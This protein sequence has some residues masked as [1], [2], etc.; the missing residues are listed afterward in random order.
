MHEAYTQYVCVYVCPTG[1]ALQQTP[2]TIRHMPPHALIS[3]KIAYKT[4]VFLSLFSTVFHRFSPAFFLCNEH[5][6]LQ[7]ENVENHRRKGKG[8]KA[9]F[10][11]SYELMQIYAPENAGRIINCS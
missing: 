3:Q 6:N 1:V 4:F 9:Y 5:A 10:P 8:E 7:F 11:S 2:C